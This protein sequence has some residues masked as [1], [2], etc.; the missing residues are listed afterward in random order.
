MHFNQLIHSKNNIKIGLKEYTL[1][2]KH[3]VKLIKVTCFPSKTFQN[4]VPRLN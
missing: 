1:F 3:L 4:F 2:Y